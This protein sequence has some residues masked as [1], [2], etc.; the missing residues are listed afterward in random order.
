MWNF[1]KAFG[2]NVDGRFH[3]KPV[4]RRYV[5]ENLEFIKKNKD[6]KFYLY[7]QFYETHTGSEEYLVKSGRIKE[8][9]MAEN[10]YYDAKIKLADE[11]VI[12]SVIDGQVRALIWFQQYLTWVDF[13][14]KRKKPLK[15]V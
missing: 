7:N 8:G 5:D 9:V 6:K 2:V 4:R 3:A 11:E 13:R 14:R 15:S 12:G 10:S 1:V